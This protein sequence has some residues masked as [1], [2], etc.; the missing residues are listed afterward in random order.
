MGKRG[1]I[2]LKGVRHLRNFGLVGGRPELAS[3]A[4][5]S[6]AAVLDDHCLLDLFYNLGYFLK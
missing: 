6:I 3:Y 4:P 5:P 1:R 2:G